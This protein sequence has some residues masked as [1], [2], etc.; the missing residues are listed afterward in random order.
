MYNL[1]VRTS[2]KRKESPQ[3]KINQGQCYFVENHCNTLYKQNDER[4]L[5]TVL[6]SGDVCNAILV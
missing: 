5:D 6:G 3:G 2:I 4:P 1:R